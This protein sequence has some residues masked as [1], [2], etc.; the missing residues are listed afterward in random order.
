MYVPYILGSL[1]M[2]SKAARVWWKI[3]WRY[4]TIGISYNLRVFSTAIPPRSGIV[5]EFA[6]ILIFQYFTQCLFQTFAV[7]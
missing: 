6:F 2:V 3:S 7:F 1:I 4:I 5:M